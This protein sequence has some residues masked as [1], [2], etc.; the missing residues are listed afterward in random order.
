MARIV[1][2]PPLTWVTSEQRAGPR[3]EELPGLIFEVSRQISGWLVIGFVVSSLLNVGLTQKP[4]NFRKHLQNG[5]FLSRMVLANLVLFP[6][7]MVMA[8]T[9]V[10]LEPPYAAG[11]LVFG[12]SAGAPF[13]IA[14][15]RESR[16]DISLAATVMT[17][18][19]IGTVVLMPLILPRLLEGV[20][21]D[22]WAIIRGLALQMILPMVLG[23][24]I[25][26]HLVPLAALIQPWVAKISSLALYGLLATMIVGYLPQ[27]V[28]PELWKALATGLVVILVG[29]FIGYMMG[30]GHNHLKRVGALATA[31][32]NTAAAM[33]VASSNFDDPRVVVVVTLVNTA[34]LVVLMGAAKLMARDAEF[35]L[36]PIGADIPEQRAP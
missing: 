26:Q 30:D 27:M 15:T 9:M 7:V 12:L 20:S 14:L 5:H 32:R 4:S 19:I 28:D 33:I 2:T 3:D 8:V 11:L 36:T 24:A 23:M 22:V 21:V 34:G 17:V 16:D 25:R 18:L 6:A 13:L 1:M 35:L 29:L 10:D 31:Q